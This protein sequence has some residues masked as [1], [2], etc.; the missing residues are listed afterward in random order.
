MRK[1]VAIAGIAALNVAIAGCIS[2]GGKP[3]NYAWTAQRTMLV[4]GYCDCKKCTNWK[5]NWRGERVVA[6]GTAKG[7][8]KQVGVTA[9]GAYAGHGTIA[10]D[11]SRYPFGTI[12]YVPGYGYGRVEDRGGAIQGDHIDLFFRT[13][14]EAL[15][16]GR[17]H[18]KVTVYGMR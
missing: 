17:Q 9:S 5:R 2:F 4:T 7:A 15:R 16:W 12:M 3:S 11:T 10:A 8:H 14:R 1:F 18:R 6:S 13:H